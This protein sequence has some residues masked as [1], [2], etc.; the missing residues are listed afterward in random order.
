[1]AAMS[2]LDHVTNCSDLECNNRGGRAHPGGTFHWVNSVAFSPDGSHV[3][4][5]SYDKTVRIWN[6]TTGEA[7]ELAQTPQDSAHT[8][9][10]M[11]LSADNSWILNT[12][13]L[14]SLSIPPPFRGYSVYNLSESKVCFG[15]SSGKVIILNMVE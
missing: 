5:G 6:A 12:G 15:Y 3:I 7:E 11:F 9:I 13:S 4:S 8:S 1:M 14:P 2:Y 10:T